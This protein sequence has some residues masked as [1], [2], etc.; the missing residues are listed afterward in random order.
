MT[1]S[2]LLKTIMALIGLAVPSVWLYFRQQHKAEIT[3]LITTH[4]TAIADLKASFEREMISAKAGFDRE[5]QSAK[6]SLNREIKTAREFHIEQT[7]YFRSQIA[8]LKTEVAESNTLLKEASQTIGT[9]T[10]TLA[11]AIQAINLQTQISQRLAKGQMTDPHY[12]DHLPQRE[13]SRRN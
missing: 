9:N 7:T 10:E 1:E 3:N 6:D 4:A 8:E 2:D 5:L 13:N 12:D 11:T